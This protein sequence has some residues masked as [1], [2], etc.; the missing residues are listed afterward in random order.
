MK[1]FKLFLLS[2]LIILAACAEEKK[3]LKK[4]TAKKVQHYICSNKCKNSGSSA[5]GVC[6]T[7]KTPYTHNQAFHKDDLL[8]NGPLVEPDFTGTKTTNTPSTNKPSQPQNSAGIYHY[9]CKNGCNGGAGSAE[10]CT[11]CG[12]ILEHNTAY[13]NK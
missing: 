3:P 8:K 11:A 13:H 6:P 4:N 2:W 5:A 12:E 1:Y 9:T 10:N 7:C